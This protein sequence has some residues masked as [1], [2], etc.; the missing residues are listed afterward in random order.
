M[1]EEKA[2]SEAEASEMDPA[3]DE[4]FPDPPYADARIRRD[5]A[6]ALGRLILAHNEVDYRLTSLLGL[7]AR[8]LDPAGG[9]D[10]LTEGTF[11]QRAT[12]IELLMKAV[13]DVRLGG[14][15]NGRLLELNRIRNV[16]AHG[17][18]DQDPFEDDYEIV[19]KAW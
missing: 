2:V 7:A 3:D 14:V 10:G 6:A 1:G 4:E 9:L 19:E 15:G 5:Y 8:K 17:H 13:P 16:V 18:F 12:A 11:H